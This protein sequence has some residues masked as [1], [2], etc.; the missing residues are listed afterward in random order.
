MRRENSVRLNQQQISSVKK[1]MKEFFD[2]V[3]CP[4]SVLRRPT[5]RIMKSLGLKSHKVRES[6]AANQR[7]R[8]SVSV[9]VCSNVWENRKKKG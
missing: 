1:I 5:L 6:D 3:F 9:C 4:L 7:K 2:V 8:E